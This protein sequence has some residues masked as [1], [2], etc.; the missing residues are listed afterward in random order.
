M[1]LFWC[2]KNRVIIG[3][4]E[5]VFKILVKM[6]YVYFIF[7]LIKKYFCGWMI[8][9]NNFLSFNKMSCKIFEIVIVVFF[10]MCFFNRRILKE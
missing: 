3:F 1:K 6:C 9:K 5:G 7:D 8:F 2:R 10:K 4:F